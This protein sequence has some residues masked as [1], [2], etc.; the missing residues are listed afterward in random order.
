MLQESKINL[1]GLQGPLLL[2]VCQASLSKHCPFTQ[3]FS[4]STTLKLRE[5]LNNRIN[6]FILK[7]RPDDVKR[8]PSLTFLLMQKH[9]PFEI[10]FF[11]S[12]FNR[13][14]NCIIKY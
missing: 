10:F 12:A 3:L 4:T 2:F 13:V 5:I 6:H 9:Q 7:T 8:N 1:T 11:A 14:I